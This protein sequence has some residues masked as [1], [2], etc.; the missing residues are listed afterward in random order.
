MKGFRKYFEDLIQQ[1]EV[2]ILLRAVLSPATHVLLEFAWRHQLYS[3]PM[4]Q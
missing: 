1:L 4:V 3:R 2:S